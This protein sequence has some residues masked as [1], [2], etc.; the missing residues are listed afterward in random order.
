VPN[1]IDTVPPDF[2]LE[3]VLLVPFALDE[4]EDFDELPHAASAITDTATST[5][6][7]TGLRFLINPPPRGCASEI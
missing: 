5:A 3:L 1:T 6:V 7:G 4:V 2:P